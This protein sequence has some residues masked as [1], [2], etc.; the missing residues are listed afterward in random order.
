[1][2]TIPACTRWRPQMVAGLRLASSCRVS[3][4]RHGSPHVIGRLQ[5][6]MGQTGGQ[7][8]FRARARPRSAEDGKGDREGWEPGGRTWFTEE[9]ARE[10]KLLGELAARRVSTADA[11]PVASRRLSL[12]CVFFYVTP[13]FARC[14]AEARAEILLWA[15]LPRAHQFAP[16][17]AARQDVLRESVRTV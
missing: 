7:R 17:C 16:S 5:P 9:D 12:R 10:Q 15:S 2:M 1:M 11:P 14:A 8:Q 4:R 13:F 3:S 6:L